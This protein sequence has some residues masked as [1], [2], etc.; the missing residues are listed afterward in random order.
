[1]R[2]SVTLIIIGLL[3][4]CNSTKS[5]KYVDKAL[6]SNIKKAVSLEKG[7]NSINKTPDHLVSISTDIYPNKNNF[8]LATPRTFVRK[9]NYFEKQTR[10]YY[11]PSDS[12]VKVITYQWD[13]NNEKS[14][15]TKN[16]KGEKFKEFHRKWTI[17]KKGLMD[18]LGKPTFEEFESKK[19]P[20]GVINEPKLNED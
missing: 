20:K 2:Q 13:K 16:E 14:Y 9:E 7:L 10:Y 6:L 12:S 15:E 19:F 3:I 4:G 1:M 18:E 5:I 8:E 17:I 11:S